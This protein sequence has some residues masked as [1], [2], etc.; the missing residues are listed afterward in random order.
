MKTDLLMNVPRELVIGELRC[1]VAALSVRAERSLLRELSQ[2]LAEEADP[3]E[4]VQPILDR[5]EKQKRHVE[6]QVVLSQ[7]AQAAVNG[8]LPSYDAVM[9]A[10]ATNPRVLARE[11]FRR[12]RVF[13][14]KLELIEVEAVITA[15]NV[16]DV[17]FDLDV[18]LGREED[19]PKPT[20]SS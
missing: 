20:R 8:E 5:L 16:E 12:A 3:I 6:R 2:V 13:A 19:D 10:R 15:A 1:T 18:A 17:A 4:R 11:V 7:A 14:P 9:N